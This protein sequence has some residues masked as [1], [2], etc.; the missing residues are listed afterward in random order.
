MLNKWKEYYMTLIL[1]DV[2]FNFTTE[3][4]VF[5]TVNI[6]EANKGV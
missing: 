3:A 5:E 4:F 1:S 6:V 2:K